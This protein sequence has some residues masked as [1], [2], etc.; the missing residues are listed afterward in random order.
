M[1]NYKA[2]SLKN[3]FCKVRKV[4]LVLLPYVI[5][6]YK[7]KVSVFKDFELDVVV[8]IVYRRNVD[9][10]SPLILTF[11]NLLADVCHTV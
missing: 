7:V 9:S 11:A 10:L 3:S 1:N 2:A 5:V 4:F 8:D 6:F